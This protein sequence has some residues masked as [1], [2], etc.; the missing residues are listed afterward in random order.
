MTETYDSENGRD[1]EGE[2]DRYAAVEDG[3]GET[4]V[5]DTKN[6]AAWLKSDAAVA[7]EAMR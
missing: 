7:V 4:V 3:G 2:T 6:D 1:A 5:Y